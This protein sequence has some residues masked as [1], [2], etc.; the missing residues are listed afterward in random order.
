[1]KPFS[2]IILLLVFAIVL[3]NQ[4]LVIAQ[5]TL[6]KGIK[7]ELKHDWPYNGSGYYRVKVRLSLNSGGTATKRQTYKLVATVS[8]YM[9]KAT[10]ASTDVVFENGAAYA[11]GELY[12]LMPTESIYNNNNLKIHVETDGNLRHDNR[13]IFGTWISVNSGDQDNAPTLLIVSSKVQS[14]S[15]H[16]FLKTKT[17][18]LDLGINT[19]TLTSNGFPNISALSELHLNLNTTYQT[20]TPNGIVQTT[21]AQAA[22]S[23]QLILSSTACD[24]IPPTDLPDSWLGLSSVQFM[25]IPFADLVDVAKQQPSS[26]DAIKRWC[27]AGG[28]LIVSDCGANLENAEEAR[29]LLH[30]QSNARSTE[31]WKIPK[32]SLLS[33]PTFLEQSV[34]NSQYSYQYA[35]MEKDE[36]SR[37]NTDHYSNVK[38]A[39]KYSLASL[40]KIDKTQKFAIQPFM[41][42]RIAVVKSD[43]SKW[44]EIDW[45]RLFNSL[46]VEDRT[47]NE[48][49][50]TTSAS[51][52][53]VNFSIEGVGK[54][55]TAAFLVLV[56]VFMLVVGPVSYQILKKQSRLQLLFFTV[57]AISLIAVSGLLIY[58]IAS[59]G[60]NVRGRVRSFTAVDH[61]LGRAVSFARHSQYSGFQ[62]Q[63]YQFEND[64]YVMLGRSS[65]SPSTIYTVQ[66]DSKTASGGDIRPR[67][68]HQIRTIDSYE[69]DQKLV[70]L[71]GDENATSPGIRNQFNSTV[72]FAAFRTKD[73]FFIIENLAPGETAR[74]T[75]QKLET[76]VGFMQKM[77]I[78]MSPKVKDEFFSLRDYLGNYYYYYDMGSVDSDTDTDRHFDNLVKGK[79]ETYLDK[80]GKYVAIFDEFDSVPEP[81]DSIQYTNK[82][83]IVNGT[84]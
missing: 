59:D 18:T 82:I 10:V 58:A 83:H 74:S 11:E 3:A 68:P 50:G 35:Y 39:D 80:P 43:M 23:T 22:N 57:P 81:Q 40:D 34:T 6:G 41:L 51:I 4:H 9:S 38:D 28:S 49:L 64:A 65:T 60:I 7:A 44:K 13:D 46:L 69:S 55:P 70:L 15:Y 37:Y 27:A 77:I 71:R 53:N 21:A 54:P 73:G 12:F 52:P 61:K 48:R 84:W 42:G 31:P 78:D 5:G 56:V 20:V 29:S 8:D 66:G 2:Q 1:M 72:R 45:R 19:P 32:P 75:K 47:I 79:L 16:S 62:P 76:T 67:M 14:A 25:L 26:F 17:K 24:A 33:L 36:D 30:N 63:P